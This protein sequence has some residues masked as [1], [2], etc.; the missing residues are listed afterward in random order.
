ML[1]GYLNIPLLPLHATRRLGRPDS[2][3][4]SACCSGN[5][6]GC[7]VTLYL[8]TLHNV[9]QTTQEDLPSFLNGLQGMQA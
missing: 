7:L 6:T 2:A 1:A 8:A 5:T 3:G 4:N 9:A